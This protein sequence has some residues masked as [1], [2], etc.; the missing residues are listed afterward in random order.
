MAHKSSVDKTMVKVGLFME[1]FISDS[2]VKVTKVKTE[3][4]EAE[5]L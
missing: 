5:T 3:N 4:T 2:D 1:D